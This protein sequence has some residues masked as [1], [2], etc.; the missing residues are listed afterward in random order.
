MILTHYLTF[1]KSNDNQLLVIIIIIIN[2]L[3]RNRKRERK[4]NE[5][6]TH[7]TNITI[8]KINLIWLEFSSSFYN[9]IKKKKTLID[10]LIGLTMYTHNLK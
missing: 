6:H 3:E 1:K 4:K 10:W 9:R 8:K 5:E 2:Q 7:F